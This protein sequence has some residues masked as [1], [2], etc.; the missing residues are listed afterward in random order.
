MKK[1]LLVVALECLC[2]SPFST[3]APVDAAA[4][5][6]TAEEQ[7]YIDNHPTL[8]FGVDPEF[9]PYEFVEG[10]EYKGIASDYIKIME[11]RTGIAFERA[12]DLSWPEAYAKARA[13]SRAISIILVKATRAS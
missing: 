1:W 6:W 9:V 7:T 2:F 4:I 12:P 5:S 13:V 3:P 11:E 8:S 10:G